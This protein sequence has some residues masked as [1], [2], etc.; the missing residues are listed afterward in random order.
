ME[1][2]MYTITG[3]T[4]N[5][6]KRIVEILLQKK[7]QVRAIGRDAKKLEALQKQGAEIL[8]GDLEDQKFLKQAFT[9]AK[10][11]FAMIPPNVQASNM[12]G[13]MDRVGEATVA[14]IKESG[15]KYVV[16]L[17]SLGAHIPSGT[18]P[19]QGLYRQENRLNKLDEVNVLHLRPG[20]F[21][22]NTFFSIPAIKGMGMNVGALK[23]DIRSPYIATKDIADVAAKRLVALDFTGKS[24]LHLLGQRDL[25]MKELTQILGK[26]IDKNDLKYVQAPYEEIEKAMVQ[27]GVSA[28]VARN[29][30]EMERAANS[31][32]LLE[33]AVRTDETTTPTTIEEFSKTFAAVYN[34][35]SQK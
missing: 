16:H 4:G 24:V 23:E 1:V 18:G 30:T 14:A 9:G 35:Q 34:S 29:Y 22:E 5:I 26:S 7:Q 25:T 11:I 33:K 28:D 17:S 15:V 10:A 2:E 3:A 31:G 19:I 21:M 32:I 27:M 8:N 20:Y 6:G 12:Q 13:F